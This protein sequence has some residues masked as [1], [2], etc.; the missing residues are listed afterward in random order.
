[1]NCGLKV[2]V[3][4][5]QNHYKKKCEN[6][7]VYCTMGCIVDLTVSKDEQVITQMQAKQL[8]LHL[9]YQCP[10][11]EVQCKMCSMDLI[12]SAVEMHEKIECPFRPANCRL[13]GCLKILPFHEREEHERHTC[14]FRLITCPQG[15][16]EVISII[17]ANKHMMNLCSMRYV[18]CPLQCGEKMRHM[19][20][21]H[22]IEADCPR[23]H[24]INNASFD[25]GDESLKSPSR[26]G[27]SGGSRLGSSGGS[28]SPSRIGGSMD[29][30]AALEVFGSN[31]SR[32]T[33]PKRNSTSPKRVSALASSIASSSTSVSV[34]E[35]PK[36]R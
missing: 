10:N 27:S 18:E 31:D 8:D 25:G 23:R 5:E 1:M 34:I 13:P 4:D 35:S 22:H 33:S 14:R 2:R 20:L 12:V 24:Q 32:S 6:R 16:G 28:R 26:L 9:K 21:H 15:C 3:V 19:K 30:S 11:R 36:K 17:R 7:M 29:F